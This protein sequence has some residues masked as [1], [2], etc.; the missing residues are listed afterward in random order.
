MIVMSCWDQSTSCLCIVIALNT[1]AME[2][3]E[4]NVVR[5]V[6]CH[7]CQGIQQFAMNYHHK[8]ET[9]NLKIHIVCLIKAEHFGRSLLK[10]YF[11][12]RVSFQKRSS[13]TIII[14]SHFREMSLTDLSTYFSCGCD[15]T[16]YTLTEKNVNMCKT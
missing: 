11:V 3:H 16:T 13:P 2:R 10:S 8:R 14:T 7:V 6:Y 1:R 9:G 5:V 4:S 15:Y 12:T